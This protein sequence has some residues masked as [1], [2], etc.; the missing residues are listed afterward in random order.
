M[1]ICCLGNAGRRTSS[2]IHSFKIHRDQPEKN[3]NIKRVVQTNLTGIYCL[4]SR[5]SVLHWSNQ[6]PKWQCEKLCLRIDQAY[7]AHHADSWFNILRERVH[8]LMQRREREGD[9][10]VKIAVLDTGI[11]ASHPTLANYQ[12]NDKNC[13]DWTNS[14]KGT[15][16]TIGHGTHVAATILKVA[17][18]AELYIGKVFNSA[19]G[20]ADSL[21]RVSEVGG[22]SNTT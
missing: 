21:K 2:D 12:F 18:N 19:F 22:P 9:T 20:D 14:S 10:K 5:L 11:D 3:R 13:R 17:P 6:T 1:K 15:E 16:D 8:P 4:I 7:S